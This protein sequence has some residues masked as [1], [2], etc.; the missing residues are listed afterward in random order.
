MKE[1]IRDRKDGREEKIARNEIL[2]A[3]E[4]GK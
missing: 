2:Y 3:I 1:K 4:R